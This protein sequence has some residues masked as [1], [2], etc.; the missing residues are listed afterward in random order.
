MSDS[1]PSKLVYKDYFWYDVVEKGINVEKTFKENEKENENEKNV[2][3][4]NPDYER[5]K[6]GKEF[7]FG[8]DIGEGERN[9]RMFHVD[10]PF[11]EDEDN[12]LKI[13]IADSKFMSFGPSPKITSPEYR[14][15]PMLF[16]SLQDIDPDDFEELRKFF[17][18]DDDLCYMN[19]FLKVFHS[20]IGECYDAS[21]NLTT[22]FWVVCEKC[23]PQTLDDYV[24]KNKI[25]SD[26]IK[27]MTYDLLKIAQ[28]VSKLNIHV[29]LIKTIMLSRDPASPFPK[30]ML[31]PLAFILA[32]INEVKNEE[33]SPQIANLIEELSELEENKEF[34]KENEVIIQELKNKKPIQD[35]IELGCVKNLK[36]FINGPVCPIDDFKFV[37]GEPLG[38]GTY[39]TVW[40]ATN[41]NG[42]IVAIKACK[43]G[44]DPSSEIN[45]LKREA[46]TMRL[47]NHKN[48][49]KF[50]SL[51]TEDSLTSSF[52]NSYNTCQLQNVGIVMEY[53]ESGNLESYVENYNKKNNVDNLPL[54]KIGNIFYQMAEAQ[55]YLHFEKRIIHRD[56]K[57]KNFVIKCEDPLIIKCCDFGCSRSISNV[58]KTKAGTPVF[59]AR[60]FVSGKSYSDKSDLYSLGICLYFLITS[61]LPFGGKD[62]EDAMKNKTPIKFPRKF[63][64]KE[65]E[66]IID[67]VTKLTK[68]EEDERISWEE[69]FEHPYVK[70]IKP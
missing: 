2:E 62:Y 9:G 50:I 60:E 27:F 47:C 12:S 22:G 42:D 10:K 53:C 26:E 11:Y 63:Q 43:N 5:L 64:T 6:N 49:V 31:S 4:I 35:I 32:K 45:S 44:T 37:S 23:Y 38:R 29:L 46:I 1:S 65:Y 69:F 39:G 15:L 66:S 13:R 41:S 48:I 67:L 68:H 55:R 57:P 59:A 52:D 8:D 14:K 17:L 28:D 25:I 3:K 61:S 20:V 30:L 21:D 70:S 7:T 54:D 18:Y 58:L 19:N 36:S 56:I 33:S 16:I 34:T 24:K 40:K 51:T